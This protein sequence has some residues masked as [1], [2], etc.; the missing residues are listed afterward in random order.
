MVVKLLQIRR[1]DLESRREPAGNRLSLVQNDFFASLDES[2]GGC[3]PERAS[4]EYGISR[5]VAFRL[6]SVGVINTPYYGL[7]TPTDNRK[8]AWGE[9]GA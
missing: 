8:E 9:R 1:S 3:K 4:P 5:Q 2:Q 7:K 6:N